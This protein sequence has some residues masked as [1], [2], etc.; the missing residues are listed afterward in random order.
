MKV[1]RKEI[2]S[3]FALAFDGYSHIKS[4]EFEVMPCQWSLVF[5]IC[6]RGNF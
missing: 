6:W 4:N 2:L 5:S 1:Q 3:I